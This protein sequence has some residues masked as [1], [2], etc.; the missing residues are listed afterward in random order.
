MTTATKTAHDLHA[1]WVRMHEQLTAADTI[2]DLGCGA[3]PIA[4]ATV[5]VDAFT[6]TEQ[7][8]LG[9]RSSIDPAALE[10][11]G[12]HFVQQRID[13]ALPFDDNEFDFAY[14][15]HVF[16]HLDDPETACL[17]MMR[18]A[19]AG[20]IRTP[21]VFAE[22]AFG[23]PYHKWMVMDGDDE[24]FFFEKTAYDFGPFGEPLGSATEDGFE[25]TPHTTPFDIALNA[26]DWYRGDE[27]FGTLRERLRWH[28]H[29]HS[30]VIEVIFLWRDE[31]RCQVIRN[32]QSAKPDLPTWM[33]G[34]P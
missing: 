2:I 22:V 12:I 31:F 10:A 4:G 5:A 18:V 14:S 1:N 7:R 30:P 34:L 23:R 3:R 11:R 15:S 20:A 24:L 9:W 8:G 6:G 21:S 33:P 16:E 26:G 25:V 19:R 17:E 28:Y 32:R 29:A 27:D 13:V